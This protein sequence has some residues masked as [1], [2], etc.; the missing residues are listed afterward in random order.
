VSDGIPF[1][2]QDMRDL[3]E[4]KIQGSIKQGRGTVM[5][6]I[7]G[8]LAKKIASTRQ[9]QIFENFHTG[10]F[11]ILPRSRPEYKTSKLS[12]KMCNFIMAASIA[13]KKHNHEDQNFTGPD[14]ENYSEINNL[15]TLVWR[16]F[17][18]SSK[19]VKIPHSAKMLIG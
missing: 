14:P 16:C 2:L 8:N 11:S 6:F 15:Q 12:V 7:L 18:A 5:A 10:Q 9:D 4:G 1:M 17:A 19:M 13:S 3:A